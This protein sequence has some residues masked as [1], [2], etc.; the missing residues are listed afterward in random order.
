[1]ILSILIKIL[2]AYIAFCLSVGLTSWFTIYKPILSKLKE[3]NE[4]VW[5]Y[6]SGFTAFMIAVP[7]T[8]L[9]APMMLTLVL[10]GPDEEFTEELVSNLIEKY[11]E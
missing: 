9:L 6:Y 8:C 2:L 11:E 1:M 3:R 7:T 5:E 4:E 10:A